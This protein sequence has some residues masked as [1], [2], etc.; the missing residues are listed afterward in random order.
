[1]GIERQRV[2]FIHQRAKWGEGE[3]YRLTRSS[4]K[5]KE[6][7]DVSKSSRR[8]GGVESSFTRNSGEKPVGLRRDG[9][10]GSQ[11]EKE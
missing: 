2:F 3:H 11:I 1:M 8:E 9:K 10:E 6:T 4:R 7:E 5:R